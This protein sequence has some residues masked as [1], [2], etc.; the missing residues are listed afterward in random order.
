MLNLLQLLSLLLLPRVGRK[1]V[2]K[3][4]SNLSKCMPDGNIIEMK[5]FIEENNPPKLLINALTVENLKQAKVEANRIIETSKKLKISIVHWESVDFP[6][7]LR[8]VDDPPLILYYKGNLNS[9]NDLNS[10]ALIG[11]RNPTKFGLLSA[12]RIGKT[13]AEQG[14]AV[15]SGL[16]KG[17]DSE[18]H[19]GCLDGDGKAIAVLGQGINTLSKKTKF[20][21]EKIVLNDGCL[22]SE[23][24]PNVAG[25]KGFFIERDRI[26]SY[27]SNAVLVVETTKTG[28]TMHAVNCCLNSK[29]PLACIDHPKQWH[30]EEQVVG[31]QF[32]IQNKKATPIADSKSL[33]SFLDRVKLIQSNIKSK[34]VRVIQNELKLVKKKGLS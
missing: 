32:L 33:N 25:N 14:V 16:A 9:F 22:I 8:K 1:S 17:C 12:K 28:G 24:P 31:N 11:T 4:I 2:Y 18:G 27:L 19:E 26:Q 5:Q 3:F 20:L 15:V 30:N 10:I 13:I 7:S 23:Y 6:D 34:R 21:S 29:K